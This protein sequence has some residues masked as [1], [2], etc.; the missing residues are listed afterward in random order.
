M[1]LLPAG[2]IPYF[3]LIPLALGIKAGWDTIRGIGEDE[4][5]AGRSL[6]LP[7]VAAVTFA[8]GGDNIGV[9]APVFV[10]NSPQVVAVYCGVFL[11]PVSSMVFLARF[12]ATRP[13]IGEWL[14]R[15][16]RYVFPLVLIVLGIVILA[17]GH[18]F[19]L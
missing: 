10:S 17:E 7:T 15:S 18:T 14:E 6:A 13:G 9:Y 11:V 1:T 16:E 2:A 4:D 8:N 3:G 19:G 12:I 5:G